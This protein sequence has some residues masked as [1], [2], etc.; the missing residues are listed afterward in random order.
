MKRG[1]ADQGRFPARALALLIALHAGAVGAEP[2]P[3]GTRFLG[4]ALRAQQADAAANPG[5]L[6]VDEGARLWR[7]PQGAAGLACAGCHGDAATSMRGVATRY[8]AVDPK[9]GR[10]FNLELRINHCR[11]TQQRAEPLPY[12]SEPLLALTAYVARQS[13]GLPLNVDTGGV[14]AP[15]AAA[16]RELFYR[17]RGQLNLSCAQCHEDHAGQT[18]RGDTISHAVPSGYPIYRLEW[19]GLGSLQRRLRACSVGVRATQFDYG[20]PQNLNLEL[21][22]AGRAAGV[23]METPAMRR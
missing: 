12:E 9:S 16:G 6:W 5:M 19:Q 7:A 23:K 3:S 17:R 21:Y 11:G 8:P 2:L 22:L 13:T 4:E 18:L 14:A 10:L 20:S 15:F 1:G